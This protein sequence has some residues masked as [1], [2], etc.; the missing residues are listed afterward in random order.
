M[1]TGLKKVNEYAFVCV[2]KK[3]KK[4]KKRGQDLNVQTVMWGCVLTPTSGCFTPSHNSETTTSQGKGDY[5]TV[6]TIS[7][8]GYFLNTNIPFYIKRA[9]GCGFCERGKRFA[10]FCLSLTFCRPPKEGQQHWGNYICVKRVH[11][12]LKCHRN[13]NK[14]TW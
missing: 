1:I 3:K 2:L 10:H 9:R 8:Y 11:E 12:S 13:V 4:K 5:T 7:M 6:S 14:Q